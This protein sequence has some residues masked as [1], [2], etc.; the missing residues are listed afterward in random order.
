MSL[1][2]RV[3]AVALVASGAHGVLNLQRKVTLQRK[4]FNPNAT[5]AVNLN[6]KSGVWH[7]QFDVQLDQQRTGQVT[8]EVHPEWAP[9]GAA[10]FHELV[11]DGY[12]S[13]VRFFRVVEGFMAQFGISGTPAENSKW[14]NIPDD[15]AKESNQKGYVTFANAG[16]NTRSTQLFIN[17]KDNAF[18][19]SQ[20]F[21]PIGKV[22]QGMEFVDALYNGYGEGAPDGDGPDQGRITDEGNTYLEHDFPQMSYIKAATIV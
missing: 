5:A 17:F 7:A 20:G 19:D 13:N 21:P 3:L 6:A 22:T 8:I 12:F 1:I 14:A 2:C 16:P 10:R 18:L 9:K 4:A 15:P 11:A